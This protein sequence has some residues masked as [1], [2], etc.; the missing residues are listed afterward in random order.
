MMRVLV[1]APTKGGRRD[2][3]QLLQEAGLDVV[4]AGRDSAQSLD[5][6]IEQ[7][8]PDVVVLEAG[9]EAHL[10]MPVGLEQTRAGDGTPVVMLLDEVEGETAVAALRAGARGALPRDATAAEILAAVHAAAAG[11]ASLPA[12]VAATVF[13]TK[14]GDGAPS[15]ADPGG[16]SLTPREAEILALLGEGLGNKEIAVRLGISDHTVKT[17]L[18]AVYEKLGAANRAEAVAT[19]LRR[20][21][22]LL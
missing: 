18:A 7:R 13:P 6:V 9:G 15:P 4:V 3:E 5:A 14:S 10:A 16:R 22:I 8:R 2:L 19:G 11:L 20:G 17:H 12:E 1:V 21:L